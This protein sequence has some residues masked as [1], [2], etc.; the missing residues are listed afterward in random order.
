M[1]ATGPAANPLA[2]VL[3][4]VGEPLELIKYDTWNVVVPEGTF[5][6]RVGADSFFEVCLDCYLNLRLAGLLLLGF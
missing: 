5:L 1:D 6:T 2:L 4:A 3:Q